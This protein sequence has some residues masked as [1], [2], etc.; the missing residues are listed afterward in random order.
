MVYGLSNESEILS[1][2]LDIFHIKGNELR[3]ALRTTK[4]DQEQ[5]WSLRPA[6]LSGA[7]ATMPSILS[8][9]AEALRDPGAAVGSAN[10]AHGRIDALR[11]GRQGGARHRSF[12][13]AGF[14]LCSSGGYQPMAAIGASPEARGLMTSFRRSVCPNGARCAT[15]ARMLSVY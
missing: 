7:V 12:T 14:A 8:A 9:T 15:P 4:P 13:A 11:I 10:A 5:R 1:G 3:A 2:L 6:S